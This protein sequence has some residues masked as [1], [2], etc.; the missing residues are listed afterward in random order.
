MSKR[1]QTSE[2]GFI[3]EGE[4]PQASLGEVAAACAV[5]TGADR[6][7]NEALHQSLL[8]ALTRFGGQR[9]RI[10]VEVL[11]HSPTDRLRDLIERFRE[12]SEEQPSRRATG[13]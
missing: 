7:E 3:L 4:V 1:M 8:V 10:T 11:R 5:R 13:G 9:V 6:D 2:G 12:E